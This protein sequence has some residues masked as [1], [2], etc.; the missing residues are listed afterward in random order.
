MSVV[1]RARDDRAG[2]GTDPHAYVCHD[3]L[4]VFHDFDLG[5]D[6][7]LPVSNVVQLPKRKH[8]NTAKGRPVLLYSLYS[9]FL[10]FPPSVYFSHL[11]FRG[12]PIGPSRSCPTA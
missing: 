11:R 4:C 12:V 6:N 3:C 9:P 2:E 10:S 1:R 8:R 5:A 7:P